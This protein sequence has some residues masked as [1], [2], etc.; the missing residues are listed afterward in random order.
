MPPPPKPDLH[1]VRGEWWTKESRY[2]GVDLK[3]PAAP[4]SLALSRLSGL[5]A[6]HLEVTPAGLRR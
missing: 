2:I 6:L 5:T 4:I 3:A 1:A